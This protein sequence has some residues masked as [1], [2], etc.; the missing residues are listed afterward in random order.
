M[1]NL[2][3]LQEPKEQKPQW[4]K[5]NSGSA[6]KVTSYNTQ[7]KPTGKYQSAWNSAYMLNM[8]I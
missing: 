3:A 7:Y 5:L 6:S 1:E 2:H 4:I 8:H